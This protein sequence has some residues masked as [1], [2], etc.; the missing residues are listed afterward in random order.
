MDL[1]IIE[2]P[3]H[4]NH[5]IWLSPKI[6]VNISNGYMVSIP[7]IPTKIPKIINGFENIYSFKE[8]ILN[9]NPYLANNFVPTGQA[10]QKQ[11][12]H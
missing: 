3:I 4:K 2:T 6:P 5:I 1:L 10:L 7:D 12:L 9:N 8:M 11:Y